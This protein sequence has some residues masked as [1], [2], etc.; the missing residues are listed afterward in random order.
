MRRVKWLSGGV[1]LAILFAAAL[2]GPRLGLGYPQRAPVGLGRAYRMLGEL[3]VMHRGRVKPLHTVAIEEFSLIYGRP[4]FDGPGPDGKT[5]SRWE[6]VAAILDWSA[7]PEF[8]NDQDLILVDAPQLSHL[9]LDKDRKWLSP[10]ILEN[11][12][13]DYEGHTLT[14]PQWVG[15]LT[16]KRDRARSGEAGASAKLTATEESALEVG[17]RYLHYSAIRDHSGPAIKPLDLLLIPRPADEVHRMYS[18]E[19]FQKGM[20]P[21]QSLSPLEA[22]VANTLVDFLQSLSSKEWAYPGEDAMFDQKLGMHLLAS[23]WIPVGIILKSDRS[24]LSRAAFPDEQIAAFRKSY[25]E[26]EAA[27]RAAPGNV[28]EAVVIAAVA[29]ARDLGTSLGRYAEPGTMASESSFN[30]F[31]PLLKATM[32]HGFAFVML[33]ASLVATLNLRATARRWSA[34]FYCLGIVGQMTGILL[35]LYLFGFRY[36]LFSRVPVANLYDTVV[37]VAM[38]TSLFG[39]GLE[40]LWRKKY[41][42]LG[43]SAVALLL[44]LLAI[45]ARILS[46]DIFAVLPEQRINRWL[47]AHVLPIASSHAAFAMALGFGMLAIV[48]YLTAIGRRSPSYRELAL[49]LLPGILLCLLGYLGVARSGGFLALSAGHERL[50]NHLRLGLAAIGGVL[51][52]AGGVSLAGELAR[53]SPR[54][55]FL[56]GAILIV[57]CSV[58]LVANAASAVPPMWAK[59]LTPIEAW[60]GALIGGGFIVTSLFG[61]QSSD[62]LPRIELLA[63]LSHWAMQIGIFLLV[64]GAAVGGAWAESVGSEHWRSDPKVIWAVIVLVAYLVPVLGRFAG[65][66]D[67]FW[68]VAA[69]VACFLTVLT[70]WYGLNCVVH[71]GQHIFGFAELQTPSVLIGFAV[72]LLGVVGGAAW[73]RARTQTG[74]EA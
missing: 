21:E 45:N 37:W 38:T 42:A 29:A 73:R 36:R 39:L 51:T 13:L 1:C 50:L 49:P 74:S 41:A 14:F 61:A 12:R 33:I 11:A 44:A 27:E 55:V 17:E 58:T 48:S 18:G 60:T 32:A 72:A 62:A 8:W 69:S 24:E 19:V 35:E 5:P 40:L 66:I 30:R 16:D 43:S 22:N 47:A 67:T 57:A 63:N 65:W 54:R 31:A 3:P 23:N 9:L 46:P 2:A 4:I 6:P 10:H 7:R 53:R 70:S 20:K 64:V 34:A 15:R 71:T 52:I 59:A 56:T 28:P 68:L 25:E 26:L